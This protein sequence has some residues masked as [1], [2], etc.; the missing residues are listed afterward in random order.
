MVS[1][2]AGFACCENIMYIFFYGG[3]SLQLELGILIERSCFPVHPILAA[4][5]SIGVCRRELEGGGG[6]RKTTL[7][8]IILP[9]VLFHGLFDFM[10]LV[11]DFIGKLVGARVEEGD[12]KIS[13]MTELLSVLSCVCVMLASLIYFYI[14][15]GKQRKRLGAA[16][17]EAAVDSSSLI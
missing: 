17:R 9:A 10:I 11:I 6:G 7:G 13:N 8:R 14:E 12:L 4:I 1:V 15:A 5:Q 16:D 2:A 3:K